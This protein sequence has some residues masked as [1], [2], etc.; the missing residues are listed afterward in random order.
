[1]VYALP[2]VIVANVIYYN[3]LHQVISIGVVGIEQ[4]TITLVPMFY[5]D[6]LV[7]D[8]GK[9]AFVCA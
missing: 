5:V 4:L 6:A 3:F 1:M 2:G 8:C 7:A 9:Y